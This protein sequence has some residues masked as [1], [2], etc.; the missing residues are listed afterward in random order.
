MGSTEIVMSSVRL[1]VRPWIPGV[2]FFCTWAV[3]CVVRFTF[4][5]FGAVI[6]YQLSKKILA[7]GQTNFCSN[8][9]L[10]KKAFGQVKFRSYGSIF[11]F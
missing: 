1:S 6:Y 5:K 4:R 10:L 3:F 7:F 2:K 9:R 11:K 8:D